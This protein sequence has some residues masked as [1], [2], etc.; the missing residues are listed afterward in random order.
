MNSTKI[1]RNF[2][3]GL[4]LFLCQIQLSMHRSQWLE[5]AQYVKERFSIDEVLFELGRH[6]FSGIALSNEIQKPNVG[7]FRKLLI[8]KDH[9]YE[10]E[11]T[12]IYSWISIMSSSLESDQAPDRD[13]ICT[14]RLNL[15]YAAEIV[16]SR[17]SMYNKE[18]SRIEHCNQ[19]QMIS[20]KSFDE[21]L[22]GR[23]PNTLETTD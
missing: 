17:I 20:R 13:F 21:L 10:V 12:Y 5:F 11:K 8:K 18:Y 2:L 22:G 19:S 7:A 3:V 6:D 16:Q 4:Y 23:W 9:L 1:Q 14:L 15:A